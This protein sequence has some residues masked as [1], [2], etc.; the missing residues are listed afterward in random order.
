MR[1]LKPVKGQMARKGVKKDALTPDAVLHGRSSSRDGNGE[2]DFVEEE[3][4]G[5]TDGTEGEVE[6]EAEDELVAQW[7]AEQAQAKGSGKGKKKNSG[8][9]G[10]VGFE[11]EGGR[12]GQV[13]KGKVKGIREK[14]D[15]KG[16]GGK[17]RKASEASE[18]DEDD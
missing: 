5:M 8:V 16:T 4:G 18:A 15:K 3:I 9:D 13:R 17:R 12:K 7:A 10:E 2:E 14:R 11:D 1:Y 6:F